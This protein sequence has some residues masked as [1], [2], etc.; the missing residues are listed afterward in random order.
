MFN[1]LSKLQHVRENFPQ[2]SDCDLS[3]QLMSLMHT[4]ALAQAQE[5]ILEKSITDNRKPN[6]IGKL[7]IHV[8][9]GGHS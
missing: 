4:I 8:F 1:D 9:F 2:S 3:P 7:I 5:C 6:I